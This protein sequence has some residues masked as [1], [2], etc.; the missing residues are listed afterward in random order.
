MLSR[1]VIVVTFLVSTG[2]EQAPEITPPPNKCLVSSMEVSRTG[3]DP[4]RSK[5]FFKY[6]INNM[7]VSDSVISSNGSSVFVYEWSGNT[8]SGKL[9]GRKKVE[10]WVYRADDQLWIIPPEGGFEFVF[11]LDK[12]RRVINV[13]QGGSPYNN[14]F[15]YDLDGNVSVYIARASGPGNEY[16]SIK[17]DR[18]NNPYLKLGA[19]LNLP[20]FPSLGPEYLSKNNLITY[21]PF[22]LAYTYDSYGNVASITRSGPGYTFSTIFT[23]VNCE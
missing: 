20:F 8:V 9:I 5:T 21:G 18:K 22:T 3:Y 23:Y 19:S 16:N 6:D 14:L 11:F 4:I 7:R 12:N 17:Y 13:S 2:C 1:I 15:T 10:N